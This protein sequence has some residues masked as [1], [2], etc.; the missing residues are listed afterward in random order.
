[1]NGF[2]EVYRVGN[3]VSGYWNINTTN[4]IGE[5]PYAGCFMKYDITNVTHNSAGDVLVYLVEKKEEKTHDKDLAVC[6]GASATFLMHR[7]DDGS[8]SGPG[9]ADIKWK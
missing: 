8:L 3:G 9:N 1:V 7:N 5:P 6:F 2:F 4:K